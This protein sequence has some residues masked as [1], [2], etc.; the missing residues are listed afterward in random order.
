VTDVND[1]A[2]QFSDD[3]FYAVE[4]SEATEI[5][6]LV[7]H[8]SAS[9]AD[10]GENGRVIYRLVDKSDSGL[11]VVDPDTG[12]VK[13]RAALDR[14]TAS[15]H[16]IVV[17]A[18]DAGTPLRSSTAVVDL[19]LTDVDDELPRFSHPVYTFSVS[20]NQP[21]GTDVGTVAASDRDGEPFN[22]FRYKIV[23]DNASSEAAFEVDEISGLLTTRLTLNREQRSLYRLKIAAIPTGDTAV[24]GMSSTAI[25][26]VQVCNE[27][28]KLHAIAFPVLKQFKLK[29]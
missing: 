1:H 3:N 18:I 9:D 16:H 22:H 29:N 26:N 11:F 12:S 25:V 7:A 17:A 6:T 10:S 19:V 20:E 15:R 27:T 2:P 23:A 24:S 5:G 21:P 28:R 13:T 8:L 14:E 4:L